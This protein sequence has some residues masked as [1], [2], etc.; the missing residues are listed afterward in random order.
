MPPVTRFTTEV[1]EGQDKD[2]ILLY[3]VEDA[4]RKTAHQIPADI[5]FEASPA[6]RCLQD[7]LNRTLHL[8]GEIRPQSGSPLL[9]K[10]SGICVFIQCLRM[11]D[12]FYR[13]TSL[14]T[15]A[16]PSSPGM[17]MMEPERI[18]SRRCSA[19]LSQAC[20][21]GLVS[22]LERLPARRSASSARSFAGSSSA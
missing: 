1:H 19:S 11:I 6:I 7:A 17:P 21:E 18:S 2:V 20:L 22:S 8:R 14:R 12:V 16:D 10:Q 5:V 3:R 9:I 4:I 15:N 13:P